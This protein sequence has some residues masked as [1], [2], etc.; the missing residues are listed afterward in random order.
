MAAFFMQKVPWQSV[1]FN[2]AKCSRAFSFR[3]PSAE[4]IGECSSTTWRANEEFTQ[5]TI[6]LLTSEMR[7]IIIIVATTNMMI[8]TVM[9]VM[10]MLF[11]LVSNFNFDFKGSYI[12]YCL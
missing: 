6:R 10:R 12:L 2:S 7:T 1:D 4:P 8:M 11:Q 3:R 5:T 9:K